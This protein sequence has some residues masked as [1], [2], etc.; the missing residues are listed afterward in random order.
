MDRAV[1]DVLGYVLVFTLITTSVALVTVAGTDSLSNV[2]DA[3]QFE[4][5]HRVFDVLDA[6]VD[7]HIE[8]QADR[9]ATEIRLEDA[10]LGFGDPVEINVSVA[11]VG[12]NRT[13]LDPIVYRQGDDRSIAYSSGAILR[14][15]PGGTIMTAGPPFRFGEE[16]IITFVETRGRSGDLSGSGR[17]LL[18]TQ[19]ATQSL[20]TYDNDG[21]FEVTVNVTTAR[22]DAWERWMEDQPGVSDCAVSG[23]TVTCTRTVETLH[24]RTVTVDVVLL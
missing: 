7:D 18:R 19:R 1:S 4:N 12:Y 10:S 23:G 8:A 3:E 21:P 6:N 13:S 5:A 2:R 20:H 11:G 9:R 14:G 24:V 15:D 22:T 16:T 17:V